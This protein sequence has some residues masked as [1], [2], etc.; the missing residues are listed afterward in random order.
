MSD[1][2]DIKI[3]EEELQKI[4]VEV[5]NRQA[6]ELKKNSEA[7]ASEIETK[8]RA[9]LTEKAEKEALQKKITELEETQA[10]TIEDL[11]KEKEEALAKAKADR[12][13]FEKRL[14]ELEATKKGLA[15]N[16]SPF[17]Q[18]ENKNLKTLPDGTQVDVS[19]LDMKEIEKQ[20]RDAFMERHGIPKGVWDKRI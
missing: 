2:K 9:E 7:Q 6:E 14:Q 1:E 8:V 18:E 4:E 3:S 10:K 16:E 17:N 5:K 20:S 11:G 13:A 19:K 12:E 15:K